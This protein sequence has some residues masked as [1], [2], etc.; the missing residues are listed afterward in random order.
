MDS[1]ALFTAYRKAR[2]TAPKQKARRARKRRA[3]AAA[4]LLWAVEV[5]IASA[6]GAVAAVIIFPIAS[7]ERGYAAFGG[8]WALVLIV[9]LLAYHIIHGAVFKRLEN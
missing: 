9:T 4:V 8:E 5:L 3:V 6:I 7:A 2:R 1:T